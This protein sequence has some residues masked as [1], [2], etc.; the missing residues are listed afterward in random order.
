MKPAKFSCVACSTVVAKWSGRC[1]S[2]QKWGS[3]IELCS[4]AD[5]SVVGL[6]AVAEPLKMPT[7][8]DEVDM[9]LSGG[10]LRGSVTLL[11]GTPGVGKSTL[12]LQLASSLA[13]SGLGVCYFSGEETIGQCGARARRLGADDRLFLA[14]TSDAGAVVTQIEQTNPDFIVVDSLHTMTSAAVDGSAGSVAQV[15]AVASCL[16]E[17][18]KRTD[19]AVLMVGHVTK[20]GGIAG[21]KMVEHLVDTVMSLEGEEGFELRVLR[22]FKHRFGATGNVGV[23]SMESRGLVAGEGGDWSSQVPSGSSSGSIATCVVDGNR[24]RVLEVQALVVSRAGETPKRVCLNLPSSR[25]ALCLAILERHAGISFGGHDVF[26]SVPG[27]VRVEDPSVMSAMALAC[28]SSLFDA[29]LGNS[30]AIGEL[31]LAGE[32]RRCSAGDARLDHLSRFGLGRL[33]T[34][35]LLPKEGS[36]AP[37]GAPE[38]DGSKLAVIQVETVAQLLSEFGL[39]IR[40]L[41][42][43]G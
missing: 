10:F 32:L 7:G 28:V 15:R 4:Q 35:R 12:A 43:T 14:S 40:R 38:T 3:V 21:P 30:A 16:V 37:T 17:V 11:A 26:V 22:L 39:A 27:S 24:L 8:V 18:A 9:V 41:K 6:P 2:C 36:V 42:R 1:P 34:P 29:P 13:S 20:D 25:L 5:C 33:V 19:T 31:G 23:F